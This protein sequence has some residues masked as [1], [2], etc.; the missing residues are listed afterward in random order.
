MKPCYCLAQSFQST[1]VRK[2]KCSRSWIQKQV[3][4][5]FLW[6][7]HHRLSSEPHKPLGANFK[8][9]AHTST[10]LMRVLAVV[11]GWLISRAAKQTA[12]WEWKVGL[13]WQNSICLVAARAQ[14]SQRLCVWSEILCNITAQA[15][16]VSRAQTSRELTSDSGESSVEDSVLRQSCVSSAEEWKQRPSRQMS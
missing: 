1:R 12:W 10:G 6:N 15:N 8:L 3:R 13:K 2:R 14:Q 4:C 16:T 7:A 5:H 11:L 9:H